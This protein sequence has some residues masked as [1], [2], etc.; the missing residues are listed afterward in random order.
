MGQL[1]RWQAL[2]HHSAHHRR[3]AL[4]DEAADFARLFAD[5]NVGLLPAVFYIWVSGGPSLSRVLK[6]A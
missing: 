3:H 5:D 6:A 4:A 2:P 1:F